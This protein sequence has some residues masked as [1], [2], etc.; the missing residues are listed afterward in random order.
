MISEIEA[1]ASTAIKTVDDKYCNSR[2]YLSVLSA[3]GI[4]AI[5]VDDR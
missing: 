1:I 5:D 2:R 4:N 3:I